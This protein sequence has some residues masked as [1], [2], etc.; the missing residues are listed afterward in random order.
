MNVKNCNNTIRSRIKEHHTWIN[1]ME[2]HSFVEKRTEES[3]SL[4]AKRTLQDMRMASLRLDF[5]AR[6]YGVRGV[7]EL[8][9][10][11]DEKSWMDIHNSVMMMY[12]S[13][14]IRAT[15]FLKTNTY[16][17]NSGSASSKSQ[18]LTFD[19]PAYGNIICYAFLMNNPVVLEDCLQILRKIGE[20]NGMVSNIIWQRRKFAQF[21]LLM[22]DDDVGVN[23]YDLPSPYKELLSKN[24]S[25][26]LLEAMCDYHCD[27]ME[28]QSE[29][30]N[31]FESPPFDLI[32]FEVFAASEK[33]FSKEV[34]VEHPLLWFDQVPAE[35]GDL[36]QLVELARTSYEEFWDD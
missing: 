1:K 25:E 11:G 29:Q 20:E 21:V 23:D 2:A 7:L 9:A 15:S 27:H 4:F 12:W 14:K 22:F 28:M 6:Y 34:K 35:V 31:E 30:S 13:T 18:N 36:N 26:Q 17:E 24:R 33:L 32:P 16:L 5:L 3:I 10:R 19:I 8:H